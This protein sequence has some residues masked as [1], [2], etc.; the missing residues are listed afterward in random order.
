[1]KE[2]KKGLLL[3]DDGKMMPFNGTM[4][5]LNLLGKKGFK[6]LNQYLVSD[7]STRV[8][9]MLFENTNYKE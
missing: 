6:Y 2:I 1:M 5:V 4:G 7:G 9:H 8:Y 3:G